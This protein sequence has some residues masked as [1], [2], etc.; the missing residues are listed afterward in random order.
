MI[1]HLERL[2]D[3]LDEALSSN[4]LSVAKLRLLQV[5]IHLMKIN[6]S[7]DYSLTLLNG[8]MLHPFEC[9][10][11]CEVRPEKGVDTDRLPEEESRLSQGI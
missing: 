8:C 6:H 4:S 3:G 7:M 5:L 1:R 9:S 10:T 11:F 2:T